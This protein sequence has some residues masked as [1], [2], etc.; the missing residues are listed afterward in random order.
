MM[1]PFGIG[2]NRA[3]APSASRWKPPDGIPCQRLNWA[4]K[5]AEG[6][7]S[8]LNAIVRDQ[9]SAFR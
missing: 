2:E 8:D 7:D 3:P 6:R 5:H 4:S 9:R 1:L